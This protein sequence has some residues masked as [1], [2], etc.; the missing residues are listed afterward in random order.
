MENQNDEN[1]VLNTS[2][3]KTDRISLSRI[4][5]TLSSNE[6]LCLQAL[7]QDYF[8]ETGIHLSM[9]AYLRSI[10]IP[11][12]AVARDWLIDLPTEKKQ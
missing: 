8:N 5:I 2:I 7:I 11:S 4:S 9:N 10:I 12:L 1:P 6:L 3:S